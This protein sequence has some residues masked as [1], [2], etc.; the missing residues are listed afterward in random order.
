MKKIIVLTALS[1]SLFAPVAAMAGAVTTATQSESFNFAT[2]FE[3]EILSFEGFD[4]NLGVLNSV[5]FEWDVDKTLVNTVAN[6]G[7]ATQRIGDPTPVT[8]TSTTIFQGLGV[9]IDLS[10]S[11]D[12]S[13]SGF[14]GDIGRFVDVGFVNIGAA[15]ATS[16]GD[17]CLSNDSSCGTG[18]TNLDAYIGGPL[19]FEISVTNSS[20]LAGSL[21]GVFVTNTGTAAGSVS[22]FYDYTA[23]PIGAPLPNVPEAS[24][25]SLM[26]LGLSLL[27]LQGTSRR[28]RKVG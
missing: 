9:A 14:T 4:T 5:H 13:T 11:D 28:R 7:N 17:V 15:S 1:V 10:D 2:L 26:G 25:V 27:V 23:A 18:F 8:A 12:L 24:T 3:S 21:N 16:S 22:I 20:S 19:L 6:L